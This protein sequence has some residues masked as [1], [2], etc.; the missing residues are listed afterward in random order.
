MVVD[1]S[2]L[3]LVVSSGLEEDWVGWIWSLGGCDE[4]I[5]HVKAEAENPRILLRAMLVKEK[6]QGSIKG[7]F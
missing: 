6:V 2:R 3:V 7:L 5:L 4:E 1:L